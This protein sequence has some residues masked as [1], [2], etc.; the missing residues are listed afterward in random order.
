MK[1][2]PRTAAEPRVGPQIVGGKFATAPDNS[3]DDRVTA[4]VTNVFRVLFERRAD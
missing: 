2:R 3:F 1:S 4:I